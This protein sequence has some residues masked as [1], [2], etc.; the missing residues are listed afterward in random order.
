MFQ[1]PNVV[2]Q[3]FNILFVVYNNNFVIYYRVLVTEFFMFHF[4][5]LNENTFKLALLS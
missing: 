5:I 1:T 3:Y 4:F 2:F